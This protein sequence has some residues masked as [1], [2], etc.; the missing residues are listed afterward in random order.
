[1]KHLELI[2]D[3]Q[4]M[5]RE[6]REDTDNII[7]RRAKIKML[8]YKGK[9]DKYCKPWDIAQ[10]REGLCPR[11]F[12][13]HHIIPLCC[14]NTRIELDNM[15]VID[16]KSHNWL[17][18]NIYTP[19]LTKCEVGQS[20]YIQLPDMDTREIITWDTILPFVVSFERERKR[21]LDNLRKEK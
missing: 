17:H 14:S 7:L 16:K 19:A 8:A 13:V 10:A 21:T 20:C 3:A 4:G 1:M 5:S 2:L 15:V 11:G 18:T 9:F 6:R 12:E